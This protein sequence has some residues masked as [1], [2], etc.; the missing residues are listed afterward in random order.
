MSSRHVAPLI[1][2]KPRHTWSCKTSAQRFPPA[3]TRTPKGKKK[4]FL[5]F[6]F[7]DGVYID[8]YFF[9]ISPEWQYLSHSERNPKLWNQDWKR[10]QKQKLHHLESLVQSRIAELKNSDTQTVFQPTAS[11][12]V[13]DLHCVSI[14][15]GQ[16]EL[17]WS[18][19]LIFCVCI[20]T[21]THT[22]TCKLLEIHLF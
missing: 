7:C 13:S 2:D 8:I 1:L 5:F 3:A 14:A 4:W 10:H 21:D 18:H 17:S 15:Q 12:T 11:A 6:G 16:S 19:P 9:F 20:C 22:H